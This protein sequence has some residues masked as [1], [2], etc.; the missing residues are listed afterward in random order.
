MNLVGCFAES[1]LEQALG[2]TQTHASLPANPGQVKL[3]YYGEENA[4]NFAAM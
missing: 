4:A 3:K 1:Q 2:H